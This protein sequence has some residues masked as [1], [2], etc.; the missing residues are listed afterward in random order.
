MG[1]RFRKSIN[2][3]G[4]FRINISKSGIGYSWGFPGYRHT[5]SPNGSQRKTYSILGTGISWVENVGRKN[6]NE[7]LNYDQNTKLI[8]GETKYFNN[9]NISD[10]GDND[11]IIKQIRKLRIIDTIANICLLSVFL[12]PVG[13][14]LKLLISLDWKIDLSY[15]M[16]DDNRKKYEYLNSFLTEMSKNDR[17]WQVNSLTRVYNTKYNAGAG[18]SVTRHRVN[19]VCKMPWYISCNINVFCLNLKSEKIYFTPDRMIVFKN[20]GGVGSKSY[21]KL[22][23]D[24]SFTN[25]VENEFVPRDAEVVSHTWKYVNKNGGPDRRF[26]DNRQI[27]VCRYGGINFKSSDGINIYLECS[28]HKLVSAMQDYFT[29]FMNYHSTITNISKKSAKATSNSFADDSA[30]ENKYEKGDG[31]ALFSERTRLINTIK[32]VLEKQTNEN[33]TQLSKTETSDTKSSNTTGNTATMFTD[34]CVPGNEEHTQPIPRMNFEPVKKEEHTA[35]ND[36]LEIHFDYESLYQPADFIK[37][38][39]QFEHKEGKKAE[40]VPFMQYYPTYSSMD[41]QQKEWYFYWRSQVRKGIYLDTDLSYIFVHVYE[42]LS[43]YGMNNADDSYKQLMELWENYRKEYPKLDGYLFEWIFEFCQLYNLDFEMPEWTDLSL[44]YQPEIK[45]VIISKHSG[46]I[47]LKLTFALIDSLCDYSLVRSKFYKDGH[48]MLMNE[49]IP[50]VVALA[51]AALYKKE[52]KGIL[53]KYVPNRPRKQTYYAFR[54]AN[55]KNSNQR[56]DITVKDYINSAKLRAYI[57]ELV[58]YAENVLRE[59]YNCRGRLRGVLLDD[60]TAKFVKAF[61]HKEYSPIKHESVPEKKTEINLNFDNIKEL[62]TQSDAVR[63]AL[64]VEE[65]SSEIKELLTDLKEA[66]EIFIA[67]PQYCRNLIDELQK[68]SWEIDYNSSCQASIDIINGLSGKLLACD[69]LVVEGNHLILED[70]YRDEFDYLYEHLEEIETAKPNATADS[71]FDLTLLSEEMK[72]LFES[73]SPYQEEIIC[74]ILS[75]TDVK[76]RID[77]IADAQMS[78]PEILVDEINDIASQYIGDILIDTFEDEMCILEQY[79]DELKKAVK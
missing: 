43:G 71:T 9:T 75:R 49:A 74:V 50:R 18:N 16:D 47:P 79:E 27:P 55:C 48:K 62:R 29:K 72:E 25:F 67:M 64:E 38:M 58:R 63:D 54:G 78:M 57:N 33:D 42:L 30:V 73:L 24:F 36:N 10:V 5:Y 35:P 13:I 37:D 8:T 69:L 26:N 66:K 19:V 40:F 52:G 31:K 53:D 70:D 32:N 2:L 59:L 12:I 20:M 65:T 28:N 46:E 14:V 44:P 61:L 11:E 21:S 68:H 45:N 23:T 3:G 51:D 41:K 1:L 34:V 4:G 17:L 6:N 7:K 60:E 76:N 77:K 15:E 22:T 39:K 56:V